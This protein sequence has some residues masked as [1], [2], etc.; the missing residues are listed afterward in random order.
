MQ[1]AIFRI[2]FLTTFVIFFY[3]CND[4]YEK[5][6]IPV[7]EYSI[8]SVLWQQH[9]AEYR[10]LTYQTFYL[11]RLRLEEILAQRTDK[12][13]KPVVV[14]D[15][16]ETVLDNS[17]FNGKLIELDSAFSKHRWLDWGGLAIADTIPGALDFFTFAAEK[18]VEVFYIS[19][20][21]PEQ[22]QRTIDNLKKYGFPFADDAHLLL[23]D[24]S[25]GKEARRLVVAERYAIILLLGDNL[26]DFSA[27]FDQQGTARRNMLVDSLKQMFGTRF[28]VFPNPM[29]GDWESYG[30]YEGQYD[31]T[32]VQLDSI[33][34][35]KLQAY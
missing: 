4:P 29:Y 21:Y 11:A 28:I 34:H 25:G 33:R 18:G 7:R 35:H 1:N 17:P 27:L 10:A 15:I 32:P 22:K 24:T 19:N 23:K 12:E 31:W 26:S 2:I 8:Q 9:S 14:T 5:S 30:I 16:D 20:R 6:G 13:K 3:S